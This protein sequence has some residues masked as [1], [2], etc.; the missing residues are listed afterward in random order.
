MQALPLGA[1]GNRGLPVDMCAAG[2]EVAPGPQSWAMLGRGCQVLGLQVAAVCPQL[3]GLDCFG[4]WRRRKRSQTLLPGACGGPPEAC[5]RTPD[6]PRSP[7]AHL[8]SHTDHPSSNQAP[9][10]RA[11]CHRPPTADAASR[12]RCCLHSLGYICGV[13]MTPQIQ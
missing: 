8:T 1:L 6:T 12:P 13:P 10:S 4:A 9:R 5:V 2:Q 11:Q 3:T 7:T